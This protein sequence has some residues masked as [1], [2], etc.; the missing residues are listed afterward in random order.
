[1]TTNVHDLEMS[2]LEAWESINE[3]LQNNTDISRSDER[4]LAHLA[5]D[6]HYTIHC[7]IPDLIPEEPG[8]GCDY[9][10]EDAKYDEDLIQFHPNDE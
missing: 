8:D 7:V 6:L 1:M 3:F 2:L 9:T 5:S 10:E 4:T